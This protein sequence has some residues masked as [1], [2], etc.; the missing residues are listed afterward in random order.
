MVAAGDD[1]R[2]EA[3]LLVG[4]DAPTDADRRHSPSGRVGQWWVVGLALGLGAIAVVGLVLRPAPS[5]FPPPVPT[6]AST[7]ARQ[8]D[9]DTEVDPDSNAVPGGTAELTSGQRRTVTVW[10]L[11]DGIWTWWPLNEVVVFVSQPQSDVDS[12][13]FVHSRMSG[14]VIW[15]TQVASGRVVVVRDPDTLDSVR[16]TMPGPKAPNRSI[17]SPT[18]PPS[19]AVSPPPPLTLSAHDG[20]V[21][22]E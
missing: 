14:R 10:P 12:S 19:D 6:P 18:P 17:A 22:T 15:S 2:Q 7:V 8:I 3:P 16:F 1:P 11:P 9:G 5:R 20:S 13:V 21:L 4:D